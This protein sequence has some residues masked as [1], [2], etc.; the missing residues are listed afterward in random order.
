MK[1]PSDS[2]DNWRD[3]FRRGDSSDIFEIID[4]AII[5]AAADF[6]NE[7][8]SRRDGIAQL[9][10][11]RNV[12]RRRCIGCGNEV[13]GDRD[14]SGGGCGEDERKLDDNEIVDE[15]TR[16]KDIL[17]NKD[18]E[19][20]GVLLRCLRKLE[21]M[22]LSVDL[23]KDTEIGKAV[24]G[25]RRHGSDKIRELAKAL[26]AEW[27]E[28]VDQWMN[29]TNE[30]VGD[31]R[32]PESAIVDEA[33]AFP[34]PPH[35]LD[36]FAPEPNGFELS[37]VCKHIFPSHPR[38]SVEPKHERKSQ[39]SMIRR[40]GGTNE[41]NVV[42]RYNK[43]QQMRREEVDV[44]QLKQTREPIVIA[45]QKRKLAGAQQDKLQALDPDARFEFAKRKLQESYQQH[46]KAK[47][48]RTIQVLETIPKQGKT[49][50]PLL[51]RP[52]R[53]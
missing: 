27:K 53:R 2:L 42:G 43:N 45:E 23:L 10:F 22:S 46:D 15:V 28:M 40:P 32:T 20:N 13:N 30:I 18:D 47:K 14:D 48:Q 11:S 21:S 7:F 19:S 3:Y 44:R 31:E 26:F 16:I 51:K 29:N 34:S 36:Y 41:A 1:Q 25:L 4:H 5:L 12:S 52:V 49:K 38:H 50:K 33:E 39:S 24:N 6:P 9:L 17:L 37:Q 8:K 35:D